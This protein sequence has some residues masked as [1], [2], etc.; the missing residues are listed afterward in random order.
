[1][2]SNKEVKISYWAAHLTTTVSVTLVLL[3]VGII[4]LTAIGV[5]G[6]TR[7]I[8]ER[9]EVTAVMADTVP[10][11]GALL[12]AGKLKESGMA[13]NIEVTG[14]AAAL[15]QWKGETG[16]DLEALFGVNPL[17]PEVT[18][19]LPA[20]YADSEKIGKVGEW[21]KSQPGVAGI[22]LPDTALVSALNSTFEKVTLLLGVVAL[23]MGVISF[24]LINNTVHLAVYA[25]RFTIH[26]MQLV[27]ATNG[28][29]RR[30]YIR[31]NMLSGLL[32]GCLAS[33]ILALALWCAPR[34]GFTDISSC[35]PWG[36]FGVT[37]AG[38]ALLGMAICGAAALAATT[39]YLKSDY[40]DLFK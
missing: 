15:A 28:F 23:V 11:A 4:A 3:L 34:A 9:L 21:L 13:R 5:S 7:R 29:I 14:K 12:L 20:Y 32:A 2:K 6:E 1:M 31:G 30:P 38:L 33:A 39:R 18:F 26:T 19:T 27:G 8:R 25:R 16:E 17:S 22:A 10:D 36:A 37:A 40:S 24:V 35:I